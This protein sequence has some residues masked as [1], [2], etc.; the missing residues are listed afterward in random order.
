MS[1]QVVRRDRRCVLGEIC[2]RTRHREPVGRRQPYGDHVL[3]QPL[4]GPYPRIEAFRHD[5]GQTIV[6]DHLQPHAG[7]KGV[8]ERQAWHYD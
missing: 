7:V 3:R 5:I 6:D 1:R 8:E 4:T 2:R